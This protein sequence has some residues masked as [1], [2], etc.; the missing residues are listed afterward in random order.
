MNGKGD[1][2]YLI[3]GLNF[4]CTLSK[5][6]AIRSKCFV[7]IS[8]ESSS[9]IIRFKEIVLKLS[10]VDYLTHSSWFAGF[11]TRRNIT[12]EIF[13]QH[14]GPLLGTGMFG[15]FCVFVYVGICT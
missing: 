12:V 15:S 8:K 11:A 13:S 5:L 9:T 2:A 14:L 10:S 6:F 7:I 3:Q 4:F 1:S